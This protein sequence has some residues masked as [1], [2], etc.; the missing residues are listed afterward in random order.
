M[1]H[2]HYFSPGNWI[3]HPLVGPYYIMVQ[4]VKELL[5][6][7]CL[8]EGSQSKTKYSTGRREANFGIGKIEKNS[9]DFGIWP[10]LSQEIGIQYPP[11]GPPSRA[12]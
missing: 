4:F 9:R 12:L 8:K 2:I 7:H 11:G 1:K 3:Q 6:C 10:T 5:N